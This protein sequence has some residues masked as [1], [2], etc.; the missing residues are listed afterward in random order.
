[1]PWPKMADGTGK[2]V[3]PTAVGRTDFWVE[4][5]LTLFIPDY[6][7]ISTQHYLLLLLLIIINNISSC[8]CHLFTIVRSSVDYTNQPVHDCISST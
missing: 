2:T 8:D 3:V 6:L 4:L 5:Q 7:I 1:M